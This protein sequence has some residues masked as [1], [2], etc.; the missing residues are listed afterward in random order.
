MH[1][2]KIRMIKSKAK[3]NLNTLVGISQMQYT[4]G[5]ES[6]IENVFCEANRYGDIEGIISLDGLAR[7][8]EFCSDNQAAVSHTQKFSHLQGAFEA[9]Q[10]CKDTLNAEINKQ[11]SITI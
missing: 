1:I 6:A 10:I 9:Y 2:A 4:V 5:F 8:C 7:L 3:E 11:D